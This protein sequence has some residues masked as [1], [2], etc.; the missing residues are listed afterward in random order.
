MLTFYCLWNTTL[1]SNCTDNT[2]LCTCWDEWE[3]CLGRCTTV[4]RYWWLEMN[5]V[6]MGWVTT[7]LKTEQVT[8]QRVW[9]PGKTAPIKYFFK[10]HEKQ[11]NPLIIMLKNLRVGAR[12]K[13]IEDS[14]RRDSRC[15][16][17]SK[18]YCFVN[19]QFYSAPL[20]RIEVSVINVRVK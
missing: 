8:F 7:A 19:L 12:K 13:D 16:E 20:L 5:I 18:L 15:L 2:G 9:E 3:T 11:N 1:S 14:C 10:R 17:N 6:R 4:D